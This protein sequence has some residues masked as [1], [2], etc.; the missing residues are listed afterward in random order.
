MP[1]L[2]T[3]SVSA[4]V[5]FTFCLF[6][7]CGLHFLSLSLA[8]TVV[9][10]GVKPCYG[11]ADVLAPQDQSIAHTASQPQETMGRREPLTGAS[12]RPAMRSGQWLRRCTS[13]CPPC[14]GPYPSTP[15]RR[16]CP[17]RHL[18]LALALMPARAHRMPMLASF[19]WPRRPPDGVLSVR[20]A[21]ASLVSG[22]EIPQSGW[23]FIPWRHV[24]RYAAP[25]AIEMTLC[26]CSATWP[27]LDL[28][29]R[30]RAGL[31]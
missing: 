29:R 26:L 7:S 21:G 12:P 30:A 11:A 1:L 16:P 24:A 22:L 31:R 25:R 4:F 3:L 5:L 17:G 10:S 14:R 15:S 13:G 2:R 28:H 8:R 19:G 18:A 27:T 23:A 20:G 9:F 6:L